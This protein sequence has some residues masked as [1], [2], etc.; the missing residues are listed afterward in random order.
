MPLLTQA[1]PT[2]RKH[3]IPYTSFFSGYEDCS[4]SAEPERGWDRVVVVEARVEGAGG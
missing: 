3:V 1:A 2:A 4:E